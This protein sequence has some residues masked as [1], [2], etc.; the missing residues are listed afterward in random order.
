M[1]RRVNN[2]GDTQD[3]QNDVDKLVTWSEKWQILKKIR[4]VK[5]YIQDTGTR[6]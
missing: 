1:F 2:D 6:M 5:A 3:L 4:N